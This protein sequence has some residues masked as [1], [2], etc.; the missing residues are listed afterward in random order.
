MAQGPSSSRLVAKVRGSRIELTGRAARW[1]GPETERPTS[2]LDVK[3]KIPNKQKKIAKK[4]QIIKI[5]LLLQKLFHNIKKKQKNKNKM[6]K[7]IIN[8]NLIK[9][10]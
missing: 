7:N 2:P 3:I 5:A 6:M 10:E 1:P 9:S 8:D 4:S